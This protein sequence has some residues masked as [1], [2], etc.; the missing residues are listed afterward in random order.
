MDPSST[1]EIQQLSQYDLD[2][3]VDLMRIAISLIHIGT[4]I[5]PLGATVLAFFWWKK[6]K[7]KS[8]SIGIAFI[9]AATIF[10]YLGGSAVADVMKARL[11]LLRE[12]KPSLEAPPRQAKALRHR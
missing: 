9:V 4:V 7:G 12:A 8:R 2:C 3:L 1:T 10:I 11:A 5:A 6:V